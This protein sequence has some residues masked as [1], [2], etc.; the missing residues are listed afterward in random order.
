D[1]FFMLGGNSLLAVRLVSRLRS[2]G[3]TLGLQDIFASPC[4]VDMA[5]ACHKAQEILEIPANVITAETVKITPEMLPLASMTQVEID[6]VVAQIPG[7]VP[8]IQDIY[9]LSPLQEGMLFHRLL[10]DGDDPYTSVTALRFDNADALDRYVKVLQQHIDRHDSLRTSIHYEGLQEP[11]Q[12]VWRE[13]EL[14]VETVP[15]YLT[16][17]QLHEYTH[18]QGLNI[19]KA[20]LMRLVVN[21]CENGEYIAR[22]V[23]HHLVADNVSAEI[24]KQEALASEEERQGF[25]AAVPFRNVIAG[26]QRKDRKEEAARF[27]QG[28]LGDIT[29]PVLAFGINDVRLEG[30][31]TSEHRIQLADDLNARLRTQ[32]TRLGVGLASLCH[33]GWAQVV[34]LCSGREEVVFGTV[35]LGRSG[36]DTEQ[37]VGMLINTLPIRIDMN[38]LGC[39]VAVREVHARLGQLLAHEQ[40]SLSEAQRCSAI[41]GEVPLFNNLLNY[42]RYERT[43]ASK[44]IEGV[45][46]TGGRERTN[47]PITV[48]LEDDGQS[49]GIITTAITTLGPKRICAYMEQ[50]LESLVTALESSPSQP[51]RELTVLPEEERSRVLYE[52]NDTSAAYPQDK[53][54]HELFEAQ[55]ERTPEAVA[56]V[57]E[58]E[59]LSYA[60]L[61]AEANRL[62]HYLRAQGVGPDE[63]VALCAERSIAMVVALLGIMKAGGAYVPLD[64]GYPVERLAY[65]MEDASPRLLLADAT[66]IDVLK[67][68]S[69]P[70]VLLQDAFEQASAYSEENLLPAEIGLNSRHLIY[71]MYTSGSTG[72]PKGVMVEHRGVV[73]RLYW[74]TKSYHV[75]ESDSILQK[76][77]FSFDISVWEFFL[78]LITGARLVMAKP[79][80]H[81]DPTYLS[82]II[83]EQNITIMH[84][85]ASMLSEFLSS[86]DVRTKA[87]NLKLVVSGGEALPVPTAKLFKTLLPGTELHNLYGPTEATIE[88]TAWACPNDIT[89][90]KTVLIGKPIANTQIYI[91]DS[92]GNPVP[93]GVTG[94]LYIGGVQV[95]RGYLNRPELTAER[96]LPDPFSTEAEARMY[97]AGD[98]ARWLADG[99]IEYLGRNDDQVKIR[100][101]RIEL[102]EIEIQLSGHPAVKE[103]VVQVRGEGEGRHLVAWWIADSAEAEVDASGLHAWLARELPDYMVPRSYV[104]LDSFPLTPNGK[105]DK[106][107]LPMPTEDSLIRG[108]Y[109][110]PKGEVEE[111]LAKHWCELL[112]I[113]QVS[114]NDSFFMLGGNSLLAVR[115]VSRL[116][117]AGYTLGLQDIFASPCLVDMA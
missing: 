58:G 92:Q 62:A 80:G 117:S 89:D 99:N 46:F 10:D 112:G 108:L 20:P 77:P 66:G 33:L 55:A 21:A 93:A 64:P 107:G 9:A 116:R 76:T 110:A 27:F 95:A 68:S 31:E 63:R 12:V 106:R 114:R 43:E 87:I 56:V 71:V 65:I 3:Y 59:Q 98:T 102:G 50:A 85:V 44:E 69:V 61:N 32:A 67:S 82:Q 57:I 24:L 4:L 7:G 40:A 72:N 35:L 84:F 39:E 17:E 104:R 74:M 30:V 34:S 90:L 86:D 15:G 48:S 16:D 47:Y 29:E 97:C 19:G 38:E 18:E 5:K 113:E 11:V 91:L 26:H 8:N 52:W 73:N 103:A 25:K 115:L 109:E 105:L 22:W 96:F 111:L 78:P 75:D 42:R 54:L 1:S 100:G 37:L 49:L 101:F 2:A 36:A 81:R 41:E 83:V 45:H 60:E 70:V 94:E 6:Q 88:V 79:Q 13:A 23:S 53:C 28:M 14:E 51:V